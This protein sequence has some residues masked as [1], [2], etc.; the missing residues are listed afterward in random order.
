MSTSRFNQ[1]QSSEDN[2]NNRRRN[3]AR[4]N[5]VFE[6]PRA[7]TCY[8]KMNFPAQ[9]LEL[10]DA[11]GINLFDFIQTTLH[12][13]P[14]DREFMMALEREMLDFVKDANVRALKFG[15]TSS[16]NRMLIHR[17]AAFFGLDHNVDN[18]ASKVICTKT[19]ESRIP[20]TPFHVMIFHDIWSD[21]QPR[22]FAQS[23]DY[24]SGNRRPSRTDVPK[25]ALEAI[26]RAASFDATHTGF[27]TVEKVEIP[28]NHQFGSSAFTPLTTQEENGQDDSE[29]DG[30]NPTADTPHQQHHVE[31]GSTGTSVESD[32]ID[33]RL[34]QMPMQQYMAPAYAG[35]FAPVVG[36]GIPYNYVMVNGNRVVPR[37][38]ITALIQHFG[39]MNV[40]QPTLEYDNAAPNGQYQPEPTGYYYRGAFYPTNRPATGS[41]RGQECQAGDN[42]EANNT[43]AEVGTEHDG[44]SGLAPITAF[45]PIYSTLQN[46]AVPPYSQEQNFNISGYMSPPAMFTTMPPILPHYVPDFNT[47][48]APFLPMNYTSGVDPNGTCMPAAPYYVL[49]QMP[50]DNT[51][52]YSAPDPS[53]IGHA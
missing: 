2:G 19:P 53:H 35:G 3:F 49:P 47:P 12:K 45:N 44:S 14:H 41:D 22:R 24:G 26:K 23:F 32:E 51:F 36:A 30:A 38:D 40:Q 48:N 13:N 31:L 50:A 16:Y 4:S 10:V 39:A 42:T 18:T 43:E 9:D 33:P 6:P 17:V 52:S 21:K 28:R 5:A 8:P 29:G 15:P 25:E 1:R 46:T 20:L 34:Q 11:N 37:T 27:P 7:A